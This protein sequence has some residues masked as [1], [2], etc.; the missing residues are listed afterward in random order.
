[1]KA[2]IEGLKALGPARLAAMGAVG[3]GTLGLLALLALRGGG[4]RMALL[5][6]DLDL[7]ESAQVTEQLT[8]QHISYKLEGQGSQILVPEDQVARARVLLAK[9]GLPSGGSVGYE[10][11]DRSD[12]LT[13]NQ[14]QQQMNQTRA[15]EGELARTIRAVQGVRA[16]RVHLVLPHREPFAREHQDAQASVLLTMAG[17]ARV[18]REGVQAILNLVAAAVPGL[19]PQNIS[20]IDSRGGVL[21]RAGEPTGPAAAAAGA[22]EIRRTSELHLARAVEEMLERTVGPGHVRAEAA[23]EM[24]FD[25]LNETQERYDPDGQV[26]RSSQTVNSNSHTTE[27]ANNVSVQNN[28]PNADA[29]ANSS[30]GSQEGR[31]E[32]TTNYEIGRT[33]RTLIR[34]QP[35]IRRISLAVMIDGTETPGPD[36]KPVWAPRSGDELAR[37]SALVRSAIGFNEQRGDH[38]EVASMRFSGMEDGP[39]GDQ[40]GALGV[41]LERTDLLRLAQ[42]GLLGVVGVL[43]LL[44]VLRPMVLRL[45]TAQQTALANEAGSSAAGTA[46]L[47]GEGSY[48]ALPGGV[49]PALEGSGPAGLLAGESSVSVGNINGQLRPSSIA[50][51]AEMV[52]RYP[53]ASLAI[54]RGWI[55]QRAN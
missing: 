26:V 16:A 48:P 50:K 22:E 11:F 55:T 1:M 9:E 7:R 45:T 6:G 28:L 37:I 4:E 39:S 13:A 15:L 30:T 35:Q 10:I 5:Y 33:V 49:T 8:R 42:T 34:E 21:A 14:F 47:A 36:G 24:D 38:V 32:E 31:Q 23:V 12:G 51:I 54:M 44:F 43:A 19:R 40:A 27:A 2:L 25:H 53:E 18:D 3:L 20:I 17:V 46:R 52:D 29:G 41:S